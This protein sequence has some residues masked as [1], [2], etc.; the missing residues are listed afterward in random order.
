MPKPEEIV[1]DN[2]FLAF[3]QPLL[4]RDP[5]ASLGADP[6]RVTQMNKN[7]SVSGAYAATAQGIANQPILQEH[8]NNRSDLAKGDVIFLANQGQPY[9]DS[10]TTVTHEFF[11]RG[12]QKL[13]DVGKIDKE[14]RHLI[15][16]R[17]YGLTEEDVVR[18]ID[19]ATGRDREGVIE[20][21]KGTQLE[22][23]SG[24]EA[25]IQRILSDPMFFKGIKQMFED[26]VELKRQSYNKSVRDRLVD[27]DRAYEKRMRKP[28]EK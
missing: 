5:V 20:Y 9:T 15:K 22:F 2:E 13:R 19:Y 1:A 24:V 11:H 7:L 21:Y 18:L 16:T 27:Y 28:K 10:G 14:S 4:E 6:S 17:S 26:A 23:G 12:V 8:V 25:N 3:L